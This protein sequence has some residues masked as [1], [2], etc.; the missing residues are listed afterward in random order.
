MSPFTRFITVAGLAAAFAGVAAAQEAQQ[1]EQAA[2]APACAADDFVCIFTGESA[3]ASQEEIMDAPATKGFEL[4]RRPV[5]SARNAAT[6]AA[7]RPTASRPVRTATVSAPTAPVRSRAQ[8]RVASPQAA[9]AGRRA[10]LALSFLNG[11]AEMTAPARERARAFARQLQDPRLASVR[12]RIEGHTN[13]VGD[14]E[15]NLELS[16]RRAEAV[17]N[18]LS[19]LGVSRER[20][21]VR[22]L[23]FEQTLPGRPRTAA[24]NRRVEAVRIS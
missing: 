3:D 19:E 5:P 23:G 18:F 2:P 9:L 6:P 14:R 24:E 13:A 1:A 20:L 15:F 4:T 22:G 12:F 16:R 8:R 17:A 10:D 11:S 7:T 21:E